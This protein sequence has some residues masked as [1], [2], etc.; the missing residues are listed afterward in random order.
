[1]AAAVE[2]VTEGRGQLLRDPGLRERLLAQPP[3][4]FRLFEAVSLSQEGPGLLRAC[5]GC[6]V[7]SIGLYCAWCDRRPAG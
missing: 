2:R 3:V 7:C 1:M 5:Y 6:G 4:L